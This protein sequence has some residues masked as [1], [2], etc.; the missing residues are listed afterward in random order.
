MAKAWLLNAHI[1]R[2]AIQIP[3][4][5]GLVSAE[6]YCKIIGEAAAMSQNFAFACLFRGLHPHRI[7][8]TSLVKR[9]QA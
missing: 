7:N 9:Y 1:P 5:A 2:N 8:D 3:N 6:L 4:A